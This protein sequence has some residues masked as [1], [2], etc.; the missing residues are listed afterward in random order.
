VAEAQRPRHDAD[1][2]SETASPAGP[3]QQ[4]QPDPF[5]T[6]DPDLA[7]SDDPGPD[8]ELVGERL[9]P[10]PGAAGGPPRRSGGVG[11]AIGA[12]MLGLD[13]A[14]GRKPR[15]EAPIV[16]DASGEPGDIDADGIE[17]RLGDDLAVVA[18]PQPRTSAVG[19]AAR[20]TRRRRG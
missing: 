9:E 5:A 4:R 2:E 13:Q 17:V 8:G 3:A 11:A 19:R 10:L 15:E 18:P 12:A 1:A 20:R 16:I 14:M 7:A 6:D